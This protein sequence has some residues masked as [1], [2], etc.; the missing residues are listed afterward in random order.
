MLD[1]RSIVMGY[2]DTT[3]SL[4][5]STVTY[6]CYLGVA[7]NG[8][9]MSTCMENGNWEPDPRNVSCIGEFMNAL[10]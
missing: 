10:S 8:P 5:G 3:P 9:N 1:R 4:K 2:S 7:L 6:A